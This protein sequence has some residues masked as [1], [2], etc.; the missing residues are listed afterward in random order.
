[1]I[2]VICLASHWQ[3]DYHYFKNVPLTKVLCLKSCGSVKISVE[4]D[5]KLVFME[6]DGWRIV[7]VGT[8]SFP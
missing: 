2:C 4:G 6:I 5:W 7:E 1:M 3:T 8:L